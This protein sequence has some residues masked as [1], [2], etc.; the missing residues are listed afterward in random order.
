LIVEGRTSELGT[1][2]AS[3]P[4]RGNKIAMIFQSRCPRSIRLLTCR[5]QV[6]EPVNL[7][8]GLARGAKAM[9][10]A[11]ELLGRVRIPDAASRLASY[12][13]QYSGGMRQRVMIAMALA[14]Q[15]RSS[16]PTSRPRRSTSPCRRRS[17]IC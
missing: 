15:P 5:L 1:T 14:C 6:A 3:A 9:E 10:L 2:P 11:K 13:H 7:H 16:S 4:F 17:S 8:R 12:P